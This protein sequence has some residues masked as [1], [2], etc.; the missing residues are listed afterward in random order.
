MVMVAAPMGI[1][2]VMFL[3]TIQSASETPQ[4]QLALPLYILGEILSTS[5]EF[6]FAM[7]FYVKWWICHEYVVQI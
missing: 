1:T 2:L 6:S 3:L 4:T 7:M 5:Q